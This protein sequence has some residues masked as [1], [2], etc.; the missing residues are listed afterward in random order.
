MK[1]EQERRRIRHLYV[2]NFR[3]GH[4][5]IGQTV[6]PRR[7]RA[8]HRKLWRQP[9]AMTVVGRV[10]GNYTDAEN[11]EYAWRY[12]AQQHGFKIYGSPGVV[13][14]PLR[15]MT[16]ERYAIAKRLNWKNPRLPP[17]PKTL[18]WLRGILATSGLLLG[19]AIWHFGL[20]TVI[21][22]LVHGVQEISQHL[23]H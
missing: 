8:Q 13:V 22:V 6:D 10:A 14:N 20:I 16:P 21:T 12:L 1:A 3:S 7:R 11:H 19:L 18:F 17:T 15:R 2:L 23:L 9:F 4:V 5:Y